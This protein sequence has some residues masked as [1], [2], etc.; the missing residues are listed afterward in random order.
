LEPALA[1]SFS[2]VPRISEE[3]SKEP[4]LAGINDPPNT[5]QHQACGMGALG[6]C[7]FLSH[8]QL[9]NS[10]FAMVRNRNEIRCWSP[11][12]G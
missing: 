11:S 8:H 12:V 1:D 2:V 4:C 5:Q 10:H 3:V 6:C 7:T 9:S